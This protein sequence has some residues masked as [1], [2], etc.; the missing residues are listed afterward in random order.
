[1]T[2]IDK[3]K[4][5]EEIALVVQGGDKEAFGVLVERYEKKIIRYG[6]KFLSTSLDIE[7]ITQDIFMNAYRNI[8]SFNTK[9]KFSSWIYRIAHNAFI[10]EL[11]KSSLRPVT[12]FDF[13]TLVSFLAYEDPTEKEIEQKEIQKM[14]NLGLD[15]ISNK[16]KEILILYY[17]EELSY[18]DISEVLKI[19]TGA[20]GVRLTRAKQALRE[21]YQGLIKKNE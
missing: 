20:V 9:Q 21:A 7:D 12:L 4:N 8:Q 5:D 10:N 11:K 3:D 1:M 19:P 16:Y 6:R 18:K 13:D 14:I 15:N 2:S 17:Q